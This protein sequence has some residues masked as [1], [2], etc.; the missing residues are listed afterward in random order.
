M[1]TALTIIGALYAL[2][3]VAMFLFLLYCCR[4]NKVPNLHRELPG[5]LLISITWPVT[6]RILRLELI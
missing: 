3:I 4:R 5:V 1:I 6:L 2:G